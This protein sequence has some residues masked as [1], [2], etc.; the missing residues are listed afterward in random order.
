[1]NF[2][3]FS[4]SVLFLVFSCDRNPI[5]PSNNNG[6]SSISI[7]IRVPNAESPVDTLV[8]P[9]AVTPPPYAIYV[10]CRD[11]TSLQIV[12]GLTV[13]VEG[14][15]RVG[16]PRDTIALINP[17]QALSETTNW[18]T[19]PL[20]QLHLAEFDTG[21]VIINVTVFSNSNPIGTKSKTIYVRPPQ[22]I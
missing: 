20:L 15:K 12:R 10:Y 16:T 22:Q 21:S 5:G 3:F 18:G 1:M 14:R 19:N 4:L 7:S 6:S 11:T 8:L 9:T 17:N 2:I 13:R